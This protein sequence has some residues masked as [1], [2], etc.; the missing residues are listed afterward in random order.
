MKRQLE[1]RARNTAKALRWALQHPRVS[2]HPGKLQVYVGWGTN[3]RQP[4]R[5]R[6]PYS[7]HNGDAYVRMNGQWWQLVANVT[8]FGPGFRARI[9]WLAVKPGSAKEASRNSY[10]ATTPAATNAESR[11]ARD[12]RAAQAE[13]MELGRREQGH[14]EDIRRLQDQIADHY[15]QLFAVRARR[16][17]AADTAQAHWEAMTPRERL[18]HKTS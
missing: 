13:S 10:N 11:A 14:A 3:R 5:L 12:Y 1:R 6:K 4:W 2:R 8:P 7:A 9:W 18:T 17:V 15:E 16:K